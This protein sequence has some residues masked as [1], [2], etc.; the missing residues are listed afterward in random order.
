MHG[1]CT[2]GNVMFRHDKLEI[3]AI[4]DWEIATLGDPLLDLGWLLASWPDPDGTGIIAK[5][6][7]RPWQ[8]FPTADELIARYASES[9]CDVHHAQ[10]FI[11]LACYKLAVL[12]E[13]THARACAGKA[14]QDL[15]TTLHHAAS[16]VLRRG[17]DW[18]QRPTG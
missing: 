16:K 13:G 7:V 3:A 1:D 15:G 2:L 14:P 9:G 4:V 12:L 6:E 11:V 17:L 10:W 5:L 18:T 8:G